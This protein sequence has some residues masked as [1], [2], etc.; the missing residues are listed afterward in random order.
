MTRAAVLLSI[1]LLAS[2]CSTFRPA[3]V[4][5]APTTGTATAAAD[6]LDLAAQSRAAAAVAAAAVANDANPPGPPRE[7]TAGELTVAASSLPPPAAADL[8]A[9][10]ARVEAALRGDLAAARK[11]WTSAGLDAAKLRERIAAADA[12][13]VREQAAS[14]AK[15]SRMIAD[16]AT[17][18][19]RVRREEEAKGQ[20]L[21]GWIFYGGGAA[22]VLLGIACLTVLSSVPIVGPKVAAS[23]IAAG[24]AAIACGRAVAWM[25]AHPVAIVAAIAVP[26]AVAVALAIANHH[27]AKTEPA[28]K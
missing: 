9:A 11:L 2:G 26:L 8:V 7:A 3:P 24:F 28:A 15:I 27:N 23:L 4:V 16:H 12:A 10:Q 1:A 6:T 19:D 22:L 13:A 17:E 20:R 5:V 21:L 25:M 18:L 14:A